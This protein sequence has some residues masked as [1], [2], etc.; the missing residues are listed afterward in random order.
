VRDER[1]DSERD[2]EADVDVAVPVLADEKDRHGVEGY[3]D[4]Q[5][6]THGVASRSDRDK[7]Q[8]QRRDERRL[9]HDQVDP[10]CR[11]E[12]G[13]DMVGDGVE[14]R[15]DLQPERW[16]VQDA[17]LVGVLSVMLG[18][19]CALPR[20]DVHGMGIADRDDEQHPCKPGDPEQDGEIRRP[21]EPSGHERR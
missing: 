16:P 8:V 12:R 1:G 15:D 2:K 3:S 5:R 4:E 7:R 18:F 14:Q 21:L 20:V 10:E 19:E 13:V 11:P 17:R 9:G 6:S